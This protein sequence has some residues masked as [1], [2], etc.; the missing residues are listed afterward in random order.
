MTFGVSAIMAAL[1]PA[2]SVASTAP[3]RMLNTR[4]TRQKS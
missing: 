2:M 3:S 1:P 4:V